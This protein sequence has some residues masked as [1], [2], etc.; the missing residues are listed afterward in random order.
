MFNSMILIMHIKEVSFRSTFI[1]TYAL[2]PLVS[3]K[4]LYLR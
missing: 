1:S 4:M 3:Y 2:A